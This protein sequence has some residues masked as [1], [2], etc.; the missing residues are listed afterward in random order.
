MGH[1]AQTI[2][3]DLHDRMHV[4]LAQLG[5]GTKQ[6]EFIIEAIR[7]KVERHEAAEEKR[8]RGR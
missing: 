1:I 7:E 6:R 3:D 2:P 4:V 8:R 5:R